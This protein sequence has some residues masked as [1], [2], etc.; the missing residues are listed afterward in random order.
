MANTSRPFKQV[1]LVRAV[2]AAKAGGM[3]V[4]RA[5]IDPTTGRIILEEVMARAERLSPLDDWQE[6]RRAR[7]P[8]RS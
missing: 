6:K 1:D 3:N 7:S 2:R 4:N 5:E 8:E